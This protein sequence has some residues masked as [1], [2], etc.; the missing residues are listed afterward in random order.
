MILGNMSWY[1][2]NMIY[3]KDDIPKC[4]ETFDSLQHVFDYI[5]YL[6]SYVKK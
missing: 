3:T 4:P 1:T 5:H 6:K 2:N